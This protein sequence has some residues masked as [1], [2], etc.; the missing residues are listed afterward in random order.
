M[1]EPNSYSQG[2]DIGQVV[3]VD[4]AFGKD[5]TV[6]VFINLPRYPVVPFFSVTSEGGRIGRITLNPSTALVP[7][8]PT[9]GSG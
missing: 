9:R 4:T 3:S 6:E 8:P 1:T 7:G 2:G 5:F